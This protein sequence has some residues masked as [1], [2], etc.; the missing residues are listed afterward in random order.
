[1]PAVLLSVNDSR[2]PNELVMVAFAAVLVPV[3][4]F[5]PGV[6]LMTALPAVAALSNSRRP[7]ALNVGALDEL[8]RMPAPPMTRIRPDKS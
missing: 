8:L 2:P 7:N 3:N 6:L 4:V 1:L 5:A